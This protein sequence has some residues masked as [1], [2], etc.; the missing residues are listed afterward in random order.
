M[1]VKMERKDKKELRLTFTMSEYLQ[2]KEV[3]DYLGLE[4]KE[5][6]LFL[7]EKYKTEKGV[8]R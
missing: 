6:I 1:V 4:W 7:A 3:K 2:L 8:R 5:L